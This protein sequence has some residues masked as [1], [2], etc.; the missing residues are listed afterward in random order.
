LRSKLRPWPAKTG[1]RHGKTVYDDPL[2]LNQR[3]QGSSPCAPTIESRT[4]ESFRNPGPRMQFIADPMRTLRACLSY[5]TATPS[6]SSNTI[7]EPTLL[8]ADIR[9]SK[10]E[11][12]GSNPVGCATQYKSANTYVIAILV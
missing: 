11:A 9:S 12:A 10:A 1:T 2:T 4:Y 7:S 6:G 5:L 3:V 8:G